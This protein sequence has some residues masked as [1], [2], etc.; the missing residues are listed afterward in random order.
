LKSDSQIGNPF[1]NN[2]IKPFNPALPQEKIKHL[3]QEADIYA[4][5]IMPITLST[6]H[7]TLTRSSGL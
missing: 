4:P 6:Q 7:L 2:D 5:T 3:Q 1:P